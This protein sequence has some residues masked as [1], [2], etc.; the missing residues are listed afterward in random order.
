MKASEASNQPQDVTIPAWLLRGRR[1]YNP[2]YAPWDSWVV[3]TISLG[4]PDERVDIRIRRE[5]DGYAYNELLSNLRDFWKP[6]TAETPKPR[7]C[8]V[9]IRFPGI[10]RV[11]RTT[12]CRDTEWLIQCQGDDC[13]MAG[14]VAY[15]LEEAVGRWNR[16]RY[17]KET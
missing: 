3:W 17:E 7:H 6:R 10:R 16:L 5:R 13:R 1:I 14:P 8:P 15:S 2:D 4:M 12:D 9:C 11:A